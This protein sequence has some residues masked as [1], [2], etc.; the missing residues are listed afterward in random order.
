MKP[1]NQNSIPPERPPDT[2]IGG[3]FDNHARTQ[4]RRAAES[5]AP[6]MQGRLR[7]A[8]RTALNGAANE[9]TQGKRTSA[10]API[11]AIAAAAFA[12]AIGLQL[13]ESPRQ[14]SGPTENTYVDSGQ[15]APDALPA[16]R[17]PSPEQAP[18]APLAMPET[19]AQI[20]DPALLLEEDP[21][22]YLWLGS[23]DV[24]PMFQ[25][26]DHDPT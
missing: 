12:L 17:E 9:V 10:F 8:R 3:S 13:H 7:A 5:L 18:D 4:Y 14:H 11:A 23:D 15:P 21:D 16:T 24:L 1:G 22:F 6:A 26:Q 25:E 2:D 20:D 19:I